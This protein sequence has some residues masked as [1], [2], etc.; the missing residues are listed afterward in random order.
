AI[1]NFQKQWFDTFDLIASNRFYLLF[2]K[3]PKTYW[4][5]LYSILNKISLE[6]ENSK[7]WAN[8]FS[9]DDE[10]VNNL[11]IEEIISK[12]DISTLFEQSFI[13][14]SL[15]GLYSYK[16]EVKKLNTLEEMK[17]NF[18]KLKIAKAGAVVTGSLAVFAGCNY[19]SGDIN[20]L[21]SSLAKLMVKKFSAFT[22]CNVALTVPVNSIYFFEDI[23][24]LKR[25][26]NLF[27]LG[28][29]NGSQA[30]SFRSLTIQSQSAVLSLLMIGFEPY[31]AIKLAGASYLSKQ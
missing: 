12:V 30:T 17:A 14:D 15:V 2:V 28:D 25:L 26:Q 5:D 29:P 22:F 11:S 13:V 4:S 23:E 19:I 8:G 7:F 9:F 6:S 20:L 27:I 24:S 16:N 31:L 21:L 3:S 18:V 10:L 1:P